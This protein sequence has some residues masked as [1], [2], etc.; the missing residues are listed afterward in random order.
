MPAQTDKLF[1]ARDESIAQ[2]MLALLSKRQ[3]GRS[4][5]PSEVARHLA[6]DEAAWRALMPTVRAVAA[7]LAREGKLIATQQDAVVDAQHAR[8]PIRLRLAAR[9]KDG[10]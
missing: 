2:A 1:D 7:R 9:S 6:K 10:A 8:G 3:P 5:C 4:I